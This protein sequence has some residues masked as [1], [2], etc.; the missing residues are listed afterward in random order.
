MIVKN[1]ERFIEDCLRSVADIA[2]QIIVVDTGSTDRTKEIARECGAEV[3]DFAW[4]DDFSAARNAS[5]KYARGN[6]IFWLDADERLLPD[7]IPHLK[8]LLRHEKKA[9][10]YLVNIKNVMSDGKTYKISSAHRLFNNHKGIRFE[11]RIHEQ[12]I[13]SV[14]RKKGEE[15]NSS[16][17]LFHL[18]Y[19]L[20]AEKQRQKDERNRRLLLKMV[21]EEPENAYA[22]FTLGQNYNLNGEN[23]KALRHYLIALQKNSFPK[24]LHV[25]LLNTIGEVNLKLM[26][27]SEAREFAQKSLA[28]VPDQVAAYYLMYRI[29]DAEGDKRE[30]IDWLLKLRQKNTDSLRKPKKVATD[31]VLADTDILFTLANVYQSCNLLK[32][33]KECLQKILE[34]EP[35]NENVFR[36]LIELMVQNNELSEA[37]RLLKE[38]GLQLNADL[39]DLLGMIQIKKQDFLAAIHTYTR[40]LQL[41]PD[42]MQI[43]R[44]LA[45]LFM[46]IGEEQK[47]NRLIQ[48]MSEIN[49]LNPQMTV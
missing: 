15:R 1:E 41:Q 5:I 14:A 45:G 16:I 6:W 2:D 10:A 20:E 24:A 27:T 36:K 46:K 3:Y 40:A 39:L 47:A 35:K 22:H 8:S 31:L 7:S 29:S 44:R 30:A 25:N 28:L 48:M 4:R 38:K 9:V 18:G 34:K 19:G 17:A 43:I 26:K 32:E 21:E 12:I 23:E 49:A 42:N 11:G 33:A 13:Y 37:E